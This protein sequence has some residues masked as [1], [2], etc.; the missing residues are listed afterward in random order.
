MRSGRPFWTAPLLAGVMVSLASGCGAGDDRPTPASTPP[1]ATS[2]AP[3]A[4]PP[5]DAC[6][7]LSQ[8]EVEASLG[9]TVRTPAR[10]DTPPT[11]SCSYVTPDGLDNVALSVT[12]HPDARAAHDTFVLALAVNKYEEFEGLG[13][14][15]YR[16]PVSDVKV[17]DGRYEV[18][19]DVA[20]S[21]EKEAQVQKAKALVTLVLQRLPQ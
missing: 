16:S 20:Q 13:D 15:A 19:L 1:G 2:A 6:A 18:G 10:A 7:L 21:I 4:G 11:F 8:A 9:K 17:L 5:I 3:P 12:V 14:R